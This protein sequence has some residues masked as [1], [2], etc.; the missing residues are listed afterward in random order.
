M[1][2]LAEYSRTPC[3][4]PTDHTLSPVS[5]KLSKESFIEVVILVLHMLYKNSLVKLPALMLL[6]FQ[7]CNSKQ[8]YEIIAKYSQ[9]LPEQIPSQTILRRS[10]VP[11][12]AK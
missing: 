5:C 1:S 10:Y 6:L 4:A 3:T 8:Y 9:S 11:V 7:L 2:A 12:K